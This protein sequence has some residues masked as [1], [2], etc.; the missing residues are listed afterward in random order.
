MLQELINTF[1]ELKKYVFVINRGKQKNIIIRFNNDNFYHLVGLHKIN[2]DM[3][4]PN[5]I[6]SKDK[7]YKYIKKHVDKFEKI[8]VNQIQEKNSLILRITTFHNILDLLKGNSTTLYNLKQIVPG[9]MYRGD[10][11]LSK[12]YFEDDEN[13]CCLLGLK[14]NNENG[15]FINCAPQSWMAS[16]RINKIIN[17]KRATFIDTIVAVQSE[18]FNDPFELITA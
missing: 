5:Y 4:F 15:E 10:Y 6:K 1:E 11:G 13:I 14:C 2:I 17:G 12:M 9:S 3:F 8:L 7:K 18:L 16:T